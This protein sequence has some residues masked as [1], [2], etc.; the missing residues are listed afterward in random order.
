[1]PEY[2]GG[3]LPPPLAESIG[4]GYTRAAPPSRGGVVLAF[5]SDP[6][7]PRRGHVPECVANP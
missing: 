4:G 2:T 3:V 6:F 5:R 1:M 7:L